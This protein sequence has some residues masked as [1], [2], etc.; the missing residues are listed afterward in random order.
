M[1]Q[2]DYSAIEQY[3]ALSQ[4]PATDQILA[5]RNLLL[6]SSESFALNPQ[7]ELLINPSYPEEESKIPLALISV[8]PSQPKDNLVPLHDENAQAWIE[9]HSRGVNPL[10]RSEIIWMHEKQLIQNGVLYPRIS[11]SG[12]NMNHYRQYH[13]FQTNGY[14]EW[15]LSGDITY[16]TRSNKPVLML[17]HIMIRIWL[18]LNL[19][20]QYYQN[21]Q[22]AEDALIILSLRNV[23]SFALGGF[24]GGPDGNH[25]WVE[26][27]DIL[28]SKASLNKFAHNLQIKRTVSKETKIDEIVFSIAKDIS[29][30]FGEDTA[31]CYKHDGS[32]ALEGLL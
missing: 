32:F 27:Y 18:T 24:G 1:S 12:E 28:N 31:K 6:P 20:D 8:V 9:R 30:A 21:F 3:S 11:G 14:I 4:L 22:Y 26:P 19:A 16:L 13:V 25:K 5:Q 29:H 17:R 10:P 15:G 23:K 7:S 2:I